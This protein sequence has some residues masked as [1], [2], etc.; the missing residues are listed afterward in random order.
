MSMRNAWLPTPSIVAVP[1]MLAVVRSSLQVIA[2]IE[3]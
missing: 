2:R 1:K 3:T